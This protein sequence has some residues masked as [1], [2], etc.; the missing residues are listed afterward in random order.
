MNP[1][2]ILACFAIAVLSCSFTD[3]KPSARAAASAKPGKP[4]VFPVAGKHNIGSFW[5]DER[6][7]GRRRHRGIDIFAS[8]GTPVVAMTDGIIIAKGN[9]PRGGK[10]VWLQSATKPWTFYYAHLGQHKVKSGQF[11]RKG[12]VIGTVGNT[13]NARTTPPHLHFGIYTWAGAINPLPHVKTA[14]K[15]LLP[16]TAAAAQVSNKQRPKKSR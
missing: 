6:D 1:F 11:V 12:Q 2:P 7:G 16:K 9:T 13:G 8:K 14:L 15:M 4:L 3:K 5:G 10:T